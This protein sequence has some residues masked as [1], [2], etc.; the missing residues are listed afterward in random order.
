MILN[1]SSDLIDKKANVV[2]RKFRT[3]AIKIEELI[4]KWSEKMASFQEK[5][6][7]E[8]DIINLQLENQKLKDLEF[9]R[10][11][12]PPGPFTKPED[13]NSFMEDIPES[14][15]MNNRMFIEI[16]F[17]KNT[18]TAMWKN[19]EVFKLKKNHQNLDASDYASNLC[20]YFDQARG[21][22]GL[23]IGDLPNVLNGLLGISIIWQSK[24]PVAVPSNVNAEVIE[25]SVKRKLMRLIYVLNMEST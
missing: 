7:T 21:I 6:F 15:D 18:S 3:E 11:Q 8:K 10:N 4:L 16:R 20:Q 23:S 17:Q 24:V 25:I 9:L 14:K 22:T 2:F 12:I 13:V 5:G 1:K 19:V